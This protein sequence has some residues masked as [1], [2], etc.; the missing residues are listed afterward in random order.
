MVYKVDVVRSCLPE[1]GRIQ[2]GVV[3]DALSFGVELYIDFSAVCSLWA[4]DV[5]P[6]RLTEKLPESFH[7]PKTWGHVRVLL[8]LHLWLLYQVLLT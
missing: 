4:R 8:I 6:V 5:I 2:A 3:A 7:H 1:E